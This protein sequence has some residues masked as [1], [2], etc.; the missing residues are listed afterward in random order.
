MKNCKQCGEVLVRKTFQPSG[1]MEELHI[2]ERRKFCDR[3]CM[4]DWMY[5]RIRV[6]NPQNSRRQSARMRGPECEICGK[7]KRTMHVH[8][9]DH[10]PCNNDPNNLQTLCVSCHVRSHSPNYVGSTRQRT[11]C[12]HCDK[13]S[14]RRGLCCTHL[15]RLK[16]YGDPLITPPRR[17]LP[18]II[19]STDGSE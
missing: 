19:N 3:K 17:G 14:Y 2:L 4:A 9:L 6:M 10:D 8:H 7:R 18:P 12:L 15:T 5:G 1:R 16:R 13:P 11:R